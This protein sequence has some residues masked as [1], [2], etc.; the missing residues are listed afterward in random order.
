[1][2]FIAV[3]A[4][5]GPCHKTTALILTQ[6]VS[7]AFGEN[8]LL[9]QRKACNKRLRI[10][11]VCRDDLSRLPLTI[12]ASMINATNMTGI[13]SNYLVPYRTDTPSV[14]LSVTNNT[15]LQLLID[16]APTILYQPDKPATKQH[17]HRNL[18]GKLLQARLRWKIL[19]RHET[20][21]RLNECAEGSLM[22]SHGLSGWLLICHWFLDFPWA[23][24]QTLQWNKNLSVF[25]DLDPTW[26]SP[27]VVFLAYQQ[28][29][30]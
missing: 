28:Y 2:I 12:H 8:A 1:M 11:S 17:P 3:C 24:H 22:E 10:F 21:F 5:T 27:W 23:D 9:L 13:S 16:T 29:W 7:R 18:D 20:E 4:W 25:L 19:Q 26:P 30:P 15:Y 14:Y 6:S